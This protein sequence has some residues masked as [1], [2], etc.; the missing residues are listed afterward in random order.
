MANALGKAR[1]CLQLISSRYPVLADDSGIC[2]D[3]L[4]GAP[5]VRSARFGRGRGV[6]SDEG[7]NAL[8][9]KRL[10]AVGATAVPAPPVATSDEGAPIPRVTA[11][12][13]SV[14][15]RAACY[16]CAAVIIDPRQRIVAVQERWDGCIAA[17]PSV[18]QRGFGYDPIFVPAEA[19]VTV[20]ELGDE[21]K[22]RYSHRGKAFR[23]L[24]STYAKQ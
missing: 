24:M 8:L 16:V 22:D 18:G 15:T 7:R 17:A 2:V 3:A 1:H 13:V 19:T 23:A 11:D 4:G 14:P 10:I 20:A 6:V 21:E 12:A 5:G 9:L